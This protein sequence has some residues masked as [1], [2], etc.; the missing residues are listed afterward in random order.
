MSLSLEMVLGQKVLLHELDRKHQ[1]TQ[2]KVVKTRIINTNTF[3]GQA[4][5][6]KEE[7]S[8]PGRQRGLPSRLGPDATTP[9][10]DEAPDPLSQVMP[11]QKLMQGCYCWSVDSVR[12][13][14]NCA[15]FGSAYTKI[16]MRYRE[17]GNPIFHMSP[18]SFL[19]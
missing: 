7:S 11:H 15:H 10:P 17:P 8:R 16:E 5:H 1:W 6:L 2:T 9:C 4:G 14:R 19:T 18:I 3:Q 12:E 13:S